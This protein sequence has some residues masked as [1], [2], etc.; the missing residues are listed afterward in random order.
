MHNSAKRDSATVAPGVSKDGKGAAVVDK[1]ELERIAREKEAQEKANMKPVFMTKKQRQ[2]AALKRLEEERAAKRAE[3]DEIMSKV[4]TF[5]K[6]ARGSRGGRDSYSRG[7]R[8]TREEREQRQRERE[9]R[10]QERAGTTRDKELQLIKDAYLGKKKKKKTILPPSQKF[11]FNFDWAAEDDT[12]ENLNTLYKGRHNASL[13][14]GRGF[15]AGTDRRE[16][17]KNHSFYEDMVKNRGDENVVKDL[18]DPKIIAERERRAR[19]KE[20]LARQLNRHWKEKKLDEMNERD[21]R[22]FKEDFNISA[23]GHNVPD[24]MRYWHEETRLSQTLLDTLDKIGYKEPTPIQRAAIPVGLCNIDVVGIAETGSGKTC[25]FLLPMLMYI[26][27]LPKLTPKTAIDGPYSLI[28]APTREL[29]QQIA[30]EADKFSAELSVTAV[31]IVG[32]VAHEEQAW[33]LR[34][35]AEIIIAT[36]G[37][38]YDCIERRYLVLNQCNYIV[39][40]EADKMLDMG[41]EPQL[42]KILEAMPSTNMRP[43]DESAVDANKR[44]RQT[45]MFSATMPLKV[46][47]L[48][49]KYLRHPIFIAVGD[50]SGDVASTVTQRVMWTTENMKRKLLND[51]L[52]RD[53]PPFIVF[54][55]AKKSCDTLLN[56]INSQGY[57]AVVIHGGKAQDLRQKALAGFKEGTYDVLVATDVVGRGIDVRGVKQVVNYDLPSDIEKYTHRIGRTGRGGDTGI[58]TSFITEADTDVMYDLR[59][60]LLTAGAN[61]PREL[62]RH[63]AAKVKPGTVLQRKPKSSVQFAKR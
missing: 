24:P 18:I 23:R 63:E 15:I 17:R 13:L 6:Q 51:I 21:W 53:E 34:N 58:A 9:K 16:Q 45:I 39:L 42:L 41:F 30:G 28:M 44:Y 62:D 36:P 35:G 38:L 33:A 57:S 11:K 43:E 60:K 31:S 32:G 40:D 29:A 26:S 50:R 7:G 19:E 1:A 22:I 46:E 8:E 59:Q 47:M 4:A 10:H 48:A 12:G 54:C 61:V 37:R 20:A 55:N 56:H 52:E 3:Q 5:A 14:F 2:A 49:K 27:T 25:A